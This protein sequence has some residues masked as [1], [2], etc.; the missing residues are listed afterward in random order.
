MHLA[1]TRSKILAMALLPL[2]RRGRR[3]VDCRL[4]QN[5]L[6][7]FDAQKRNFRDGPESHARVCALVRGFLA[8]GSEVFLF[9]RLDLR[10][11]DRAP[12]SNGLNLISSQRNATRASTARRATSFKNNV[13]F[14]SVGLIQ[15]SFFLQDDSSNAS[16]NTVYLINWTSPMSW[17]ISDR[18]N[19]KERCRGCSFKP[20]WLHLLHVAKKQHILQ[21]RFIGPVNLPHPS[22]KK[23]HKVCCAT[24]TA[25]KR[26]NIFPKIGRW[27]LKV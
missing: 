6:L 9:A 2:C 7:L 15:K 10:A 23:H 12:H 11:I 21:P 22:I 13:T 14:C 18:V 5:V 3:T 4:A 26:D 1:L 8:A 19:G 27:T 24:C 17:K 25:A 16:I 20:E